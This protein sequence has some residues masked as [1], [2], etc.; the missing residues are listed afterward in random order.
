VAR[1]ALLPGAALRPALVP[2]A[3]TLPDGTPRDLFLALMSL[4]PGT[5]PAG[6][7]ADGRILVH[8]LDADQPV[9][10][11]FAAEAALFARAHG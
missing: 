5:L 9:A 1:L 10:A 6:T 7:D 4:A 11:E 8:A 3:T 2:C